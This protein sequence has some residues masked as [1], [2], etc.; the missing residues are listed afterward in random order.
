MC[1]ATDRQQQG[2]YLFK[3]GVSP[4]ADS[5]QHQCG[6]MLTFRLSR[7]DSTVF[8]RSVA[9]LTTTGELEAALGGTALGGN[10]RDEVFGC[11]FSPKV[12]GDVVSVWTRV[13][14]NRAGIDSIRATIMIRTP[15]ATNIDRSRIAYRAHGPV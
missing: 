1:K 11:A 8:F 5:P 14:A 9:Q 3:H 7:A 12:T 13:A 15:G 10:I 2:E 6:G 4:L